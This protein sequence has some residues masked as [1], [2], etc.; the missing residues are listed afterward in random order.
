MIDV[1]D[2][3]LLL[4]KSSPDPYSDIKRSSCYWIPLQWLYI[5]LVKNKDLVPI[6]EIEETKKVFY[7]SQVVEPKRWKRICICQALYTWDN[8][9]NG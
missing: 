4:L 6:S 1:A 7:W 9:K 3:A 5:E 8:L 2:K